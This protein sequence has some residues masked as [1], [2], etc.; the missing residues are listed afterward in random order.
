MYAEDQALL[1][2]LDGN[3]A[4]ASLEVPL[5]PLASM[6]AQYEG[7]MRFMLMVGAGLEQM[8]CSGLRV[9][10]GFSGLSKVVRSLRI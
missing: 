10:S 4:Q 9:H 3:A 5:D 6:R 2:P 1:S 7:L 8:R